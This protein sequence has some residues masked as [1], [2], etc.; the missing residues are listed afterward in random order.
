MANT[1][2]RGDNTS[3]ILRALKCG[4]FINQV[5]DLFVSEHVCINISSKMANFH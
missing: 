1:Q 5:G 2:F 4:R 3:L